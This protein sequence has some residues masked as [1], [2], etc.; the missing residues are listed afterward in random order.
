MS[1][2]TILFIPLNRE[3]LSLCRSAPPLGPVSTTLLIHMNMHRWWN[4]ICQGIPKYLE[5]TTSICPLQTDMDCRGMSLSPCGEKPAINRLNH[6]WLRWTRYRN[7]SIYAEQIF[8]A[9][10]AQAFATC[11]ARLLI[12]ELLHKISCEN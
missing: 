7:L 12:E 1:T 3:R 9:A 10:V 4:V 2:Y 8:S 6:A 5:K 11:A